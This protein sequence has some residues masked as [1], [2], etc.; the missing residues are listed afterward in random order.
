MTLRLRQLQVL[1][2]HGD[3]TPMKNIFRGS[4]NARSEEKEV[5]LWGR[6]LPTAAQLDKLRSKFSVHL[7]GDAQKSFQQRPFGYLTTKGIEQMTKRGDRLRGFCQQEELRLDEV[8]P[9]QVQIFSNSYTRTQLSVQALLDGML[10]D[11][12]QLC[13]PVSVLPP[14]KDIINTYGIFPEIM[15]LK[16]DLERDNAEL[17]AR[18]YDMAPVKQELTRLFPAV[19]SGQIPFSWMTAADYFV[20]RR[21]HQAPYIPG[22]EVHCDVTERHL[23]FRFH[24]FYSHRTILKLVAGRLMHNVLREMQKALWDHSDSKTIVIYS[25]H[26]VSLLS[27][28]RTMDAEIANDIDWWPE[29]S[30]AL[31]L[32]LLED[33]NGRF[34]VRA[35]LNG[36]ILAISDGPNGLCTPDR[37]RDMVL[38]RIGSHAG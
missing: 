36:E 16:A 19:D 1:H 38:D 7:G 13:P 6:Q 32:E 37:F 20:C 5:Q 8:T 33:E 21:A 35:R 34:F 29:Y 18:E 30:S 3:R 24:Q 26:D 15:E 17:A 22:T 27:V 25:G 23:G 14:E 11:Q 10:R 28:L 9:E 12:P 4:V 2:R 31:A